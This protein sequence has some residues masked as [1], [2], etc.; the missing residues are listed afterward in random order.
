MH[1]VLLDYLD[2]HLCNIGKI[3]KILSQSNAEQLVHAFVPPRMDY[4]NF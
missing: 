4:Y 3:M 2:F 1:P